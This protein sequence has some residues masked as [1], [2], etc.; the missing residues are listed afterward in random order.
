MRP[1]S[2][3]DWFKTP[4]PSWGIYELARQ[5]AQAAEPARQTAT[6]ANRM[7]PRLDGMASPAEHIELNRGGR[8]CAEL[9]RPGLGP[10]RGKARQLITPARDQRFES[11]SLQ[12]RV[13][14]TPWRFKKAILVLYARGPHPEES[15]CSKA[16]GPYMNAC[17]T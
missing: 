12:Q 2:F 7:G 15:L 9:C 4:I 11:I 6:R 10:F 5:R 13:R 1:R 3:L 8:S 17:G 14:R 16:G